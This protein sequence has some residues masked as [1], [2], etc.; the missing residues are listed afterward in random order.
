MTGRASE[1]KRRPIKARP[2]GVDTSTDVAVDPSELDVRAKE[3]DLFN[4]AKVIERLPAQIEIALDQEIPTIPRKEFRRVILAGMGGSALPMDVLTDA[5]FD[6]LKVP[7]TVWRNYDFPLH[8]FDGSMVIISS[9]SGNTEETISAINGIPSGAQYVAVICREDQPGEKQT[10]LAQ[11]AAD[12]GYGVVQIPVSR[13]P[14]G[15]QPRS[16]VGYMV[17]FLGRILADVG[18]LDDPSAELEAVASFLRRVETRPAGERLAYWLRDRIPVVYTDEMHVMSIARVAKIKFNENSKR[19]AFF[20]ALP[21]ANHNEMTGFLDESLGRFGILYLHD[22]DSHPRI[23]R[24]FNAMKDVFERER[25]DHVGF[26]EWE[27]PGNT[28]A[29]R[30]F[31]ALAFAEWCSYTLAL[32]GKRDPTPVDLVET[33]KRELEHVPGN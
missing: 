26:R 17:T 1:P 4:M 28:R 33:F 7:I 10:E 19:P 9:F 14:A 5:F 27:I 18:V 24:R 20:N 16:A 25:L 31:A 8:L 2:P 15:F 6:R 21:E 11:L 13:E 23:R 29:Q 22:P 32:L 12:G 30:I 3:Y